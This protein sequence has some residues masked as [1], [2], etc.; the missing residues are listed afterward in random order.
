MQLPVLKK[1]NDCFNASF[2]TKGDL[3][4][5]NLIL[6]ADAK[7]AKDHHLEL[8]PAITINDFTYRG[9]I[10]FVDVREA[11][12]AAYQKRPN[13]CKLEEIWEAESGKR[14]YAPGEGSE[15]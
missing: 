3:N 7:W 11:I 6:A 4:S 9:D 5:E 8:H 1:T 13:Q 12:C 15:T 10:D 2:E 14:P